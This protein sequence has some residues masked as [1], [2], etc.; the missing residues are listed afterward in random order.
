MTATPR[1]I[2]WLMLLG[3]LTARADW[4]DYRGPWANGHASAPADTK[5]AGLP[6]QWSE[7]E[8]VKW[9]TPIP[10][11]GWSS[12]VVLGNQI[13]LTTATEDGHDFFA[14]CVDASSGKILFNEKLFHADTPEPLGNK[15][16]CYASPSPVIELGR[17]YVHFG[18]YGTAC[19][20][21]QTFKVIWKRGD[22]PCRHYRGPASSPIL[23]KD[24][25]ILTMDGID[26]QY[27][28]ALD[29]QTGRTVWKTDRT[30]DWNDLNT[31]GRPIGD[32]DFRKGF[33]TPL[34]ITSDSGTQM[35]SVG[36]K[37]AYSYDPANGRELWKF[38]TSA[39]SPAPRP[40]F[41]RGLVFIAAGRGKSEWLALRVDGRGDL[42]DAQV[43]WRTTRNV[44][45]APSP[46][47]VDDL[48]FSLTD[49]GVMCC[50]EAAT[51]K[52]IWQERVE[53]EYY[54]SLLYG[55]GNIYCFNQEGKITVLKAGRMFEVRATNTLDDGFMAS[56]AVAGKALILR[57]KK[58]LYRIETVLP[59]QASTRK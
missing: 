25:L 51:G 18:S 23:Y 56:P 54:A 26:M 29:K 36:A 27:V 19:L 13:W 45:L 17:V 12:P 31:D 37:A 16:N 44:P 32:G 59:K 57:T 11:R 15:V 50:L 1:L 30:A 38:K 34:I 47:L 21:T 8:N 41:G 46:L 10:D 28:V 35:I 20:D 42:T 49:N 48:L 58:N 53:G 33:G 4:P 40:L 6:V 39:H 7:T 24:I 5:P 3:M 55:D 52:E 14:I 22:L 2:V 9:K 43:A